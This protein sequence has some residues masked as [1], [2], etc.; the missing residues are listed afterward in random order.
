MNFGPLDVIP[1]WCFFLMATGMGVLAVECGYRFGKWRVS[2]GAVEKESPIAAMVGSLLGLL[3][4]LLAFTFSMAAS[5]FDARRHAVEDEANS[6]GTTYLR[7]QLLPEPQRSETAALLRRYARQRFQFV[8]EGKFDELTTLSEELHRQIWTR[9]VTAA[10]QDRHSIMTGLFV[11]SLNEM[12]DLH[13]KRIFVGAYSR[14]PV[15]IWLALFL[16]TILGM[17]S[18]GYQAGLSVTHRSP[19]MPVLA[20]AFAVV[21]TMNVDL[22]RGYEGLLRVNQ[23]PM[24]DLLKTMEEGTPQS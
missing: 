23:Q 19:E 2:R 9:A 6:I 24:I 16:L 12:I 10:D 7:A 4:F 1:L 11:Q 15:T 5:R 13:S 8:K 18:V 22:D 20:L 3:A 14:I 21:L 17:A